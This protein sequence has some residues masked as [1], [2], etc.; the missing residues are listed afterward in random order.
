[1]NR[2]YQILIVLLILTLGFNTNRAIQNQ[3]KEVISW[4]DNQGYWLKLAEQGIVNYNPDKK[5]APAIFTG[6]R[7]KAILVRTEDSPDIPVTDEN[8]TQS[9]NSIAIDPFDESV[10]LNSN[11]STNLDVTEKYGADALF[12]FDSGDTWDGDI[13]GPDEENNGDPV[14]VIGL[15]GRWF[16][17]YINEDGGMGVSYSDDNGSTWSTVQA[18]PNPGD[19]TDKC[20]LCIDNNPDSPYEGN[21][22]VAWTN[23][24]GPYHAEIGFS[25]STDNGETWNINSNISSAVEAGSHNQGVN[26]VTGPNGELYAFW[27]IYDFWP[28]G[29]SDENA[30]GMAISYDGGQSWSDAVR[31]IENIRGIRSTLTSKDLRVNSFPV[32]TIDLSSGADRGSIYVTWCNHGVPGINTGDDIDIYL[33]KSMDNGESWNTPIRINTDPPNMGKEHF[34]QWITCDNSTGILSMVFYDDRNV[35]ESECEVYCANSIDGGQTWEDFKVGDVAFTPSPIPGLA[36]SYMGDYLGIS[37]SNGM[38]YPVWTD[39]R[40]GYA[41]SYCSPYFTDPVNRPENLTGITNHETGISSLQWDFEFSSGFSYFIIYRNGDSIDVTTG[42]S[43]SDQLPNYGYYNYR[44]TA[45]Y[46][47]G[48][49][50]GATGINLT[51]GS[52]DINVNPPSLYKHLGTNLISTDTIIIQNN[53]QLPLK[54]NISL[55]SEYKNRDY[56]NASGGSNV[57]QE[58]IKSVEI[59][60]ISNLNTGADNYTDYSYLSTTMEVGKNYSIKIVNGNPFDYDQ[61]AVWIDWDIN[62]IFSENE[63]LMLESIADSGYFR[64]TISPPPGSGSGQARMRIR[65]GYTGILSPC[66]TTTFG[67][68]EDYTINCKGWMDI[69]PI[70][71]IIEPSNEDS[72]IVEYNTHNLIPDNYSC[73]ASVS[74]N[75]T[76]NPIINID[77]KLRSDNIVVNAKSTSDTACQGSAVYLMAAISG[78]YISP[79]YKWHSNPEGFHS[80]LARPLTIPIVPA[81][82][83]VEVT[84]GDNYAIDSVFIGI[85]PAPSFSLGNDTTICDDSNVTLEPDSIFLHYQWS[86]GDTSHN[87]TVDSSGSINNTKQISLTAENEYGCFFTDE[88]TITFT[89]CSYLN[90]I[91]GSNIKLFPNPA[92]NETFIKYLPNCEN[93]YINIYSQEGKLV[94]ENK[95]M[96]SSSI[97]INLNNLNTG[98]Y[99]LQ[100]NADNLVINKKLIIR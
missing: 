52:V 15:S 46:N 90:D 69:Y 43:Y 78:V 24:G 41:M 56:C 62:E 82:Y 51:W 21:L 59:D 89:D 65:L 66:G 14:S 26:L 94:Y 88:I 30:I 34:M 32:A 67:E 76:S 37:A 42:T 19:L 58:Y 74:S 60:S 2:L 72:V 44:V 95:H 1:M 61:C 80:E 85:H 29:G 25:Y 12:S 18:A 27:A 47:N 16:I 73:I 79:N 40:T 77:I 54:Y 55:H 93:L 50:S 92:I 70:S 71:G 36:D 20:H 68:V 8:S 28:S 39:N 33:I 31:I 91:W 35:S 11:N 10:L 75:D 97:K 84:E 7:I 99:L 23:V 49:E 17:N 9:E 48:R 57:S 98:T 6:S 63:K 87:I 100:L 64:G 83:I 4:I 13:E 38:V 45:Y 86:T 81:W 3:R 22:Y 5:A 53:G 96:W